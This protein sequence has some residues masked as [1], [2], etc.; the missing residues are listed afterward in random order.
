MPSLEDDAKQVLSSAE[1]ALVALEACARGVASGDK[2]AIAD[3]VRPGTIVWKDPLT[4]EE[5]FSA[6]G[7]RMYSTA[8]MYAEY[9]IDESGR[10]QPFAE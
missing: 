7:S 10:R 5:R 3:M 1:V 8:L 4:K 2:M 6:P 9:V